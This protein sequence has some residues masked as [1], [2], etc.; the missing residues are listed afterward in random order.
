MMY[1]IKFEKNKKN[2]Y[3]ELFP[4]SEKTNL[5]LTISLVLNILS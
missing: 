1:L 4:S 2:I 5:R 3:D